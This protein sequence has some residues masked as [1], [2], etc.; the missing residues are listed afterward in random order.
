MTV[1]SEMNPSGDLIST[2]HVT[3]LRELAPASADG[4]VHG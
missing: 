1:S 2:R 3:L 4:T